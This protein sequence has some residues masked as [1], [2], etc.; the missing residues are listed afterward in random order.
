M[1]YYRLVMSARFRIGV[2][3]TGNVGLRAL[4]AVIEHPL[5]ELTAVRVYSQAKENRDAGE[6][7]DLPRVG[8]LTTR[9]IDTVLAAR[10]DCV[11]Y[12]PH[13]LDVD[14][15]CRLL[16]AGVNIATAYIGFNHRES[17]EATMRAELEAA[18]LKGRS[19]LYATGSS[20]GWATELMPLT[21]LALQRR[22]DCLTIHDYADMASR[23]SPKMIFE[24]LQFGA[25]L[26]AV[27]DQMLGTAASTPPTFRALADA[28][29]LPLDEI[30]TQIEFAVARK[31]EHIAAGTIEAGT[32]AARRMGVIGLRQGKPLLQRFSTWYVARDIQPQWELQDSGW[33][34]RVD[35]DMPL[36]VSVKF[37]VGADD[38]ARYSPGLTAH[39]VVNAVPLVC[40]AAPG[41]VQTADLPML[42][43]YFG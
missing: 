43:P 26:D 24:G 8:V 14:D 16:A 25:A 33:R 1:V 20:P 42:V 19:S 9:S 35:G 12:L 21:L 5:M 34:F 15:M 32:I 36:D 28:V 10:P 38:Y 23:N 29:G 2:W 30:R 4:R 3:G 18:C 6:L 7:C 31:R 22:F 13:Q 37:A 27:R 11:I 40:G 17:V 39:P 41:I